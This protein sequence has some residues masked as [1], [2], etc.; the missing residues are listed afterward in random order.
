MSKPL[1]V[2][3]Q[4][5]DLEVQSIWYSLEQEHLLTGKHRAAL[6]R[7][8]SKMRFETYARNGAKRRTR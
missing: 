1:Y 6:K 5:T 7:V 2:P 3:N 4:L 8:A